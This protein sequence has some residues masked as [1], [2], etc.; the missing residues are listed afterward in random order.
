VFDCI[1]G[2]DERFKLFFEE[3]DLCR[4][5]KVAGWDISTVADASIYHVHKASSN[6]Y[7]EQE[8]EVIRRQSQKYYYYKYYGVLGWFAASLDR[9]CLRWRI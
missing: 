7:E 1:G 2:F 9:S 5:A 6:Q 4:R 3:I 8:I